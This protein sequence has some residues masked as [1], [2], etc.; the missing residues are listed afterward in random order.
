MGMLASRAGVETR[1]G[2]AT[3]RA[4]GRL[5]DDGSRVELVGSKDAVA[6]RFHN[7]IDLDPETRQVRAVKAFG[8]DIDKELARV[9]KDLRRKGKEVVA[10]AT[11]TL[12][13]GVH[14][15]FEHNLSH[16]VQ[17]LAKIA[18]LATVWTLGDAFI[19]TVAGAQYRQ[20]LDVE[21]TVANF[22]AAG[23]QPIGRSLF[24]VSGE[25]THHDIACV[26]ANGTVVTGVRL[27]GEPLF[28]IT[29]AVAVPELQLREGHGRLVTIDATRRAFEE[30]LLIP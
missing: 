3:W 9:T 16:A 21:P 17:G 24:K 8:D 19:T 27:F 6:F 10:T 14:G 22:E 26:V 29:I 20:W 12:G 30:K 18:Y 15:S 23:L 11:K 28:E 7:P 2:P 5:V 4:A 13:S 25:P 1:N